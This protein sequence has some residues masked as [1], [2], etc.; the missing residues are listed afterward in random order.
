MNSPYA[1]AA[2]PVAQP[3]EAAD[4]KSAKCGFEPHR[5][6]AVDLRICAPGADKISRCGMVHDMN[7][8]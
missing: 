5:G 8:A 6:H 1:G 7:G 4:L 2:A 3:A